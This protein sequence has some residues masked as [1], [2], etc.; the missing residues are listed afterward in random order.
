ML[1][2]GPITL[3]SSRLR[4]ADLAV[5]DVPHMHADAVVKR[6]RPSPLMTS[7]IAAWPGAPRSPPQQI[8]AASGWSAER[9]RAGR[10]P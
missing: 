10:H 2:A 8:G 6:L 7:F 3:K 1:T 5:H 4:G 9:W